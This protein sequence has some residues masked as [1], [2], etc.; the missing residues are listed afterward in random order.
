MQ[1]F[2]KGNLVLGETAKTMHYSSHLVNFKRPD[3]SN[4]KVAPLECSPQ[5][6]CVSFCSPEQLNKMLFYES[7]VR[8]ELRAERAEGKKEKRAL[9]RGFHFCVSF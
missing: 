2:A 3:I 6:P 5:R 4:C 9:L 1:K 7:H 8:S